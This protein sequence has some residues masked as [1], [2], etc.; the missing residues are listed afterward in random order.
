MTGNPSPVRD[1]LRRF[2]LALRLAARGLVRAPATS[3]L[4]LAI[5][6]LG[7]AAPTVFFSILVGAI[8]PLP[9]PEGHQVVRVDVVQPTAAGQSLAVEP[10][11]VAGLAEASSLEALGAFRTSVVTIVD[12]GRSAARVALAELSP[13]VLPLL[14]VDPVQGRVPSTDEAQATVLLGHDTWQEMYHG[15]PDALGRTVVV[16]GRP[17]AIVGVMPEG[18]GFPFDQSAWTV[19]DPAAEGSAAETDGAAGAVELVGRLAP[20][21]TH[22]AATSE[23]RSIWRR[24]DALREPERTGAVVSVE[25]FTG[26]RGEGDETAAFVGLVLIALCLLLIACANVANLLLVRASERVRALAVQSALGA[27]RLQIAAQLLLESLL[28]ALGGGA[29]GLALAHLAVQAL[30]RSLAA[31][32]FGYFWMRLAVDG[33]VVGFVVTL[34]ALTAAVAGS[35][36]VARVL[37]TD[38]RPVLRDAAS[39][40]VGGGGLW[41]RVFVTGQLAL[42][43]SALVAAALTA[44]SMW[45]ARDFSGD[46]PADEILVANVLLEEGATSSAALVEAVTAIPSVQGAA[47]ALGAPG[48]REPWGR[49]E[50]DVAADPSAP[51]REITFWNAVT[52]D[53]FRA[54]GLELRA[55]RPLDVR[56]GRE[57]ARV[58]VVSESFAR[59]FSPDRAMLGRRVRVGLRPDSL[60]WFTVVGVVADARIGGG[61]L[62][63]HDR[64]YLPFAQA[65]STSPLVVL[66]AR[67]D[68]VGLAPGLRRAVAL[69][70]SRIPLSGVRSLADGHAYMTRVP[71][72]MGALAMGGGTAGLLVAAVGLYGLLAFR[73]RRR[74]RELGVRLALGADRR[75]LARET[76]TFALGQ[77]VPAT[78][79]GLAL[80]W[81]AG[82]LLRVIVLGLDPRAPG[83]LAAVGATFVAVGLTAVAVPTARAASTDPAE[84][85]RAD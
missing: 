2:A 1:A 5:L 27:G 28:L 64:V 59:R 16:A 82:P 75:R 20:G 83:T 38:L 66:R 8:R 3:V 63:R 61:D 65:P 31:E 69:V 48:Y 57:A 18:F 55:G 72:A 56:D 45:I 71:R 80:A 73:V 51:A 25:R 12:E 34:V 32:H 68:A 30:E 47:L 53:Y 17:R 13:S 77:I 84:A 74:R 11:D 67:R 60:E 23:L 35:I 22:E 54:V 58:A 4:A 33:T 44:R 81:L 37:G 19:F 43:C 85:L 52:P 7:L 6:A 9:V 26:G 50:V 79:V 49:A 41:G 36:P 39:V 76:L 14:R 21:A 70:D 78:I 24:G 10:R 46:V 29:L 42:S 15:D 40:A 62:A